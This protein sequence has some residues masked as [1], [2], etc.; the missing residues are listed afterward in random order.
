MNTE[1]IEQYLEAFGAQLEA[2]VCP[3]KIDMLI[4]GGVAMMFNVANRQSTMDVDV[5][6]LNIENTW[7]TDNRKK[8]PGNIVM[9]AIRNVSQQYKL[10]KREWLNDDSAPFVLEYVPLPQVLYWRSFGSKLDAYWPTDECLLCYKILP[11]REKDRNDVDAL[12]TKLNITTRE[13]VQAILD[14][15]V[16]AATQKEYLVEDTIDELF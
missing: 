5:V 8:E 10:K 14:R 15:H 11:F 1:E 12:L 13:Q 6:W 16:P 9:K 3:Q 2:L 4:V 7:R